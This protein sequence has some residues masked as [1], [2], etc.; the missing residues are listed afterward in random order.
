MSMSNLYHKLEETSVLTRIIAIFG[1][2][3]TPG[4]KLWREVYVAMTA[5]G[6]GHTTS[7]EAADRAITAFRERNL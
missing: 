4:Q 6:N 5:N 1:R 3:E 2:T 7:T